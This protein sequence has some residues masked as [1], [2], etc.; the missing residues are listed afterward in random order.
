MSA[1][2]D[3]IT[4]VTDSEPYKRLITFYPDLTFDAEVA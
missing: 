2:F 3:P 1:A 4:K